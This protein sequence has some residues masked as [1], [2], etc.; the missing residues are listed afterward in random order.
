MLKKPITFE[1]VIN[2]CFGGFSLSD[3][4]Q[5]LLAERKGLELE[6][7]GSFLVVAGTYDAIHR[8]LPRND[9]D[10][11]AV[12]RELGTEANGPSADLKIVTISID[13]GIESFDG[14]ESVELSWHSIKR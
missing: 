1:M 6:Q 10:M 2:D 7:Q 4:A 12:V 3:K 5:R 11:I 14:K 9:P 13:P 8:I